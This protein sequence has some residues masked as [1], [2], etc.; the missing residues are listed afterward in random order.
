MVESRMK[1]RL[2][3]DLETLQKNHKDQFFV[4]FPLKDDLKVWNIT[5]KGA[6]KTLYAGETYTYISPFFI[7]QPVLA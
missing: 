6:P 1:K 2:T 7:A 4:T 5:F 3:K